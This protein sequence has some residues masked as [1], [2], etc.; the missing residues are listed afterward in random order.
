MLRMQVFRYADYH[1]RSYVPE[2]TALVGIEC[3]CG[4]LHTHT[5]KYTY[6][7]YTYT[8]TRTHIYIHTHTHTEEANRDPNSY[9]H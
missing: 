3:T 9:T 4:Q 1:G 7:Q 5:C 6:T 8:N 2:G